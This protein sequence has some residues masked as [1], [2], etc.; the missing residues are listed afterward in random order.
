MHRTGR[1][2]YFLIS[3]IA[4][5]ILM[6]QKVGCERQ[7]TVKEEEL[8]ATIRL[9]IEEVWNKENL[10]ALDA[11]YASD[12]IRHRPPFHDIEGLEA[13]K[14][15]VAVVRSAYPDHKTT[16]HEIIVDNDKVAIRYT[17][18]GTHTGE[19]LSIPPTGKQ[20]TVAGCDVYH[21]E[22]GKVIEE[23]DHEGFLSLYQQIGYQFIPPEE[24]GEE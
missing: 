21:L 8:K 23:W 24:K 11:L 17:W 6:V 9:V 1:M 12:F 16:I 10:D 20:V 2:F 3:T 22:N 14:Q 4:V 18:Q 13:H 15:R 19:G 7:K 5:V